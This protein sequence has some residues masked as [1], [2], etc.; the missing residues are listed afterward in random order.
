MFTV[1]EATDLLQKQHQDSVN[2]KK[3]EI[4]LKWFNT[5]EGTLTSILST[6]K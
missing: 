4:T 5:K 3:G 6:N 2:L 1:A